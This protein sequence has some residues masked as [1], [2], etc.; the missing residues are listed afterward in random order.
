MNPKICSHLPAFA[1]L[2]LTLTSSAGS[3]GADPGSQGGK[4]GVPWQPSCVWPSLAV[5][6]RR[7][8]KDS[9]PEA[10]GLSGPIV[11][12]VKW[13]EVP[14]EHEDRPGQWRPGPALLPARARALV[15]ASLPLLLPPP[16]V[17][18]CMTGC[19][20]RRSL[21]LKVKTNGL[22]WVRSGHAGSHFHHPR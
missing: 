1:S 12:P 10:A 19:S 18:S 13:V 15:S 3:C 9:G 16:T 4:Q 22:H 5:R 7:Q 6:Y 14:E 2:P 17:L 11:W 8:N 21:S 20:L